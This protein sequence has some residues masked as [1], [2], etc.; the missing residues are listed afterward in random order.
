VPLTMT[1]CAAAGVVRAQDRTSCSA[2][3]R[4]LSGVVVD[5]HV[6]V[7]HSVFVSRK[8]KDPGKIE[9][10]LM[11]LV[12][13]QRLD[14][15]STAT[16]TAGA[17]CK[18]RL[19]LCEECV[20]GKALFRRRSEDGEVPTRLGFFASLFLLSLCEQTC[21]LSSQDA[22]TLEDVASCRPKCAKE[23]VLTNVS[24][25]EFARRIGGTCSRDSF[26]V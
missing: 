13:A 4:S 22:F 18:A 9:E 24:L 16:F 6:T 26:V 23:A 14:Y 21:K 12:P 1:S 10:D 3:L 11:N 17:F 15:F 20:G 2:S 8:Q 7:C 25:T 19:P 5:T